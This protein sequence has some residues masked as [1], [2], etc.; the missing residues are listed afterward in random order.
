MKRTVEQLTA[1]VRSVVNTTLFFLGLFCCMFLIKHHTEQ[2]NDF[3]HT[4]TAEATK[5]IVP[6]GKNRQT[7]QLSRQSGTLWHESRMFVKVWRFFF[8]LTHKLLK[9]KLTKTNLRLKVTFIYA[10]LPQITPFCFQFLNS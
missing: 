9:C 6:F 7:M 10:K 4:V 5:N 8:F 3:S 2:R 1:T